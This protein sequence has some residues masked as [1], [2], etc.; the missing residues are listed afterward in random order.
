MF[1]PEHFI[2]IGLC[3]LFIAGMLWFS[4]KKD[5]PLKHA[6]YI[7]TVICALSETSKIMCE[8]VES[9]EGGMHLDPAALPFHL[10]SLMLFG[11]LFVTF[12]KDGAVKQAVIDFL[13]VGGTVGSAF[14]L[15]IPTNGVDF[16]KIFAYQCF[17]YHAGLLWFALYLM[18]TK[19]A[20]LGLRAFFRNLTILVSLV[21]AMIYINSVLSAYDTNFMYLVRP[22]MEDLP[23]LNLNGGWY[24]YFLR[25]LALGG[26]IVFLFHLP[27]IISERK[28]KNQE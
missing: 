5:L 1:T 23:Y 9:E 20:K 21:L 10:C 11:V 13:A 25:L 3:A 15:L 24:V 4:V 6:G 27:F 19:K 8:M 16:S 28:K 17:V 26:A 18:V 14:A 22:P 12:G 2:W 7:M